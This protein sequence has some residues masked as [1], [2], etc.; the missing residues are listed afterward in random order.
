MLCGNGLIVISVFLMTVAVSF[1]VIE[2]LMLGRFFS[3]TGSGI[4]MCALVLF[5]QVSLHLLF[6]HYYSIPGNLTK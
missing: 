5:L 1:M 4:S 2:M 6:S 3:A